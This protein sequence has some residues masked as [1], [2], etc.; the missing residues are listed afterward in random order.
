MSEDFNLEKYREENPI[1]YIKVIELINQDPT[2]HEIQNDIYKV[3][4]LH[5]PD[6]IYKYFSLNDDEYLNKMKLETLKNNKVYLA[7]N[8]AMNDPFEGK[9]FFYDNKELVK[10][11]RLS[12]CDGRII[13]DFSDYIRIASFTGKSVNCMPMWAH[14]ANNHEGFCVEYD[15]NKNI[16]LRSCLFPVQYTDKRIDIT[17]IMDTVT[18]ELIESIEKSIKGSIK[19]I[20]I[21]NFI[22]VWISTYYNCIKH[23]SWSY[24]E[25]IRCL[26]GK[27]A[28]G[29]PYMNAIPSAI[30]IGMNCNE[31]KK[32]ELFDIAY[33]LDIPLYQMYF[34]E[35][36]HKYELIPKQIR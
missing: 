29:S 25:E 14:Y 35:K 33:Q 4:R 30:Y 36:N 34:D 11:E 24:E 1:D 23:K 17:N 18:K 32:K 22:L 8:S 27:N 28:P 16:E 3:T 2:N 31:F 7:E 13:D 6:K 15:T 19:Q 9:A 12:H 5:I 20:K 10:Y 26:V 21:N